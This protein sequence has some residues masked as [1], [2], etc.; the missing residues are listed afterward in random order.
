MKN[1]FSLSLFLLF[2]LKIQAQKSVVALDKMNVLYMGVTNPVSIAVEGVEDSKLK[3]TID[4]GS[5]VKNTYGNYNVF[6]ARTGLAIVSIEW[7]GG[8][9]EKKFK[10]KPLPDPIAMVGNYDQ[11]HFK[12]ETDINLALIVGYKNLDFDCKS[13]VVGFK[14][15]RISINGEIKE[16]VV[17]GSFNRDCLELIQNKK[18]GDT[19]IYS[20]IKCLCPGDNFPRLLSDTITRVIKY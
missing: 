19:F 15:T 9:A 11:D 8:K 18:I 17:Q 5:I 2:S 13:S 3:V 12:A 4:N 7:Q 16:V 20:D 1:L 6:T 14:L 10:V